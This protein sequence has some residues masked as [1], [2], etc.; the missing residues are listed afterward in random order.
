MQP[1]PEALIERLKGR[2]AILVSGLGC[3]E[4]AELPSWPTL[5]ERLVDWIES[6]GDKSAV[7]VLVEQRQL[8]TALALLRALVPEEAIVEVVRDAYPATT[9]V[10]E[11][12]RTIAKAPWRGI[13]TTAL[14]ACWSSAL[15]DDPELADRIVVGAHAASLE[16]GR[17][18]FLIQVSGRAD[19]AGSLCL[20][21]P[22]VKT[23]LIDTG[24]AAFIEGLH[25]KWS[26]VFVGFTPS[27][28]DLALLAGRVLA[29]SPSTMEHFFVAP[30]LSPLDAHRVTSDLGL[31][32]V[33]FDGTLADT[34]KALAEGCVQGGAKPPVDDVEAWL[35]RLTDN[36]ADAEAQDAIEQGM[37]RLYED[38]QWERLV[39]AQ[40]SRAELEHDPKEQA[41]DLYEAG[42]V[43]DK[44]LA[45]PERAYPVLMMALRLTPQDPGLLADAKRI[46]ESSGQ[47]EAFLEELHEIEKESRDAGD[48]GHTPGPMTLGVALMLA[49]EPERQDEAVAAFQRVLDR[50]PTNAEAVDGMEILLRKA[51]RWD[52]LRALFEKAVECAPSSSA[53][54]AKLEGVYR[55]LGQT[56]QLI[57]LFQS[58]LA[59]NSEDEEAKAKLEAIYQQGQRWQPLS[60]LY[61][62]MLATNPADLAV[63][64]K[65]EA[66]YQ[67]TQQWQP[68]AAMYE[69]QLAARPDDDEVV[70]KIEDVYR[71]SEQW[72]PLVDLL[73]RQA[74]RKHADAARA[75]RVERATILL[76]KLKDLDGALAQARALLADAPEAAE[77]IFARCLEREP[78][79]PGALA[80]L[81]E[82]A[83]NKGDYLRA[84]KFLLDAAERTQNPLELGRLFAEA[85]AIQQEHLNDV[86]KATELFE[87]AIAAD[88]EQER[89]SERLLVLREKAEDWAGTEPLL[90]LALRKTDDAKAEAKVDLYRRLAHATRAQEKHDK[91]IAALTSAVALGGGSTRLWHELGDLHAARQAWAEA[92]TSYQQASAALEPSASAPERA[93]LLGKLARCSLALDDV[94]SARRQYEEALSLLP[95]D[96]HGRNGPEHASPRD[97]LESLIALHAAAERWQEVIELKRRL[98]GALDDDDEKVKQLEDIGD[99]LR[100]K[101]ND[102]PQA[103]VAYEEAFTLRP[104]RR[105]I[106]YKVLEYHT[107]EKAWPSAVSTL[108][109]L[110]ALE[111]DPQA[112]AKLHYAVAA[113]HRDELSDAPKALEMFSKVLDDSPLYPKAFEAIERLLGEAKDWKELERAYRKQ[114]KRLPADAP[115]DLK[116]RL[117]DALAEVALKLHDKESAALTMEV[118]VSMDR[119]NFARQ[120][121]LAKMYFDLGPS[122]ADKAIAQHQYLLSKKPDRIDSYKALAALFFQSGAHDKMWCVAG[123]MT[124][125]GK[126]DPPLQA[127]YENFRPTQMTSVPGKINEELWRKILHPD[128]DAY[129]D[130]LFALLSPAIAMTTAQPHKALGLDKATKVDVVGNHWS[131]APALRYVCNTIE[132][133]LPDVF[134]KRDVP[135]TLSLVNLKEKSTLAPALV[136]GLGFDQLTSQS[137]VVFDLAKRMVLLRPERF[138]RF[139]LGTPSALEIAARAGLQVG[140]APIGAGAHGD[141][142]DKMAKQLDGYLSAP[143]RAELKTLA[144]RYVDAR[145]DRIDIANWI[146]ATDLT[147]SRAALALCGDI[148]AAARVLALEPSGQ[149]PMPPQDRLKDLLAFFVSDGHFAVRAA[150]G[151][152]VNLTPP[153]DPTGGYRRH[154]SHMQIKTQG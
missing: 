79:Q 27:D 99:I 33:A 145:G 20:A 54:S 148:V 119:D 50:E 47:S 150:L 114:I 132:I 75:L 91:A 63:Q 61:E 135:G 46:A 129:L 128:E 140:G 125:L 138:P 68:L 106:L 32:P 1:L 117:W 58:R 133:A 109:K 124:C 115:L 26:F 92:S 60:A 89:A 13:I 3:C 44:E 42:M 149:S 49:A 100:D 82:L 134:V 31:R 102:W 146:V 43:L 95:E 10:P 19:V 15:A 55:H 48:E 137:Q 131:Y 30:A 72:R 24:A 70:A 151:L 118:A 7:R 77:Q 52:D 17:G 41:A 67:R 22:D 25:K 40:V 29:N 86:G 35:D 28:P 105:Q 4:L 78:N 16:A 45:A 127:L 83:R 87:R 23:K 113:I 143:L 65:L 11:E 101:Q 144:R 9:S 80:A 71:K 8:A 62:R 94:D 147:A 152:Q 84:A 122:G 142:V 98:L 36:P 111:E 81:A 103:M 51:G 5:C 18:R 21:P 34:L 107:Q 69:R 126:A 139:A 2:Q 57:E 153:S 97:I 85:G 104:E 93:Q 120:E 39:A 108:D 121:R 154:M 141:A 112:R 130:A 56:P 123:A 116:L 12:V 37:A 53:L 64:E 38:K 74:E 96:S 73:D 59:R 14:D 66:I 90:E 76:D 6:E 88:P 136:V 110:I